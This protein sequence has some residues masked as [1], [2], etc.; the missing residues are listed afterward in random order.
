MNVIFDFDGVI[1][2]SHRIK[3]L[4]FYN[5]FKKYGIDTAKRAKKFHL[6]NIGKSRY[7]KFK[8]ILKNKFKKKK[9]K[10]EIKNLDNNFDFFVEKELKKLK[11]SKHLIKF[12]KFNSNST[13]KF[14]STGTPKKKIIKI[15]KE[16]KL[17]K[18]FDKVYGSPSSKVNHIKKIKE[19]NKKCIFIGDSIEDYNAAKFTNI[20]FLLKINSENFYFRKKHN[21]KTLSSFKFLKNKI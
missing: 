18:Y 1:L 9:I 16:K 7:F 14:I 19:N 20:D 13:H 12:L 21:L 6:K 4:A 15:L 5:I 17:L 8:Y 3:T 10:S 11:P 2:N